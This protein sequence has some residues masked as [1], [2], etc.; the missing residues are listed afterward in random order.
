MWCRARL[1]YWP[2][3]PQQDY[4]AWRVIFNNLC[5]LCQHLW[6]DKQCHTYGQYYPQ[7]WYSYCHWPCWD[8]A[9]GK[10]LKSV[11]LDRN[12]ASS[13]AIKTGPPSTCLTKTV[14]Y[15]SSR[16]SY[17]PTTSKST[18]NNLSHTLTTWHNSD[19]YVEHGQDIVN[20]LLFT[21]DMSLRCSV[22]TGN[23]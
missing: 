11:I 8:M 20:S 16:I 17:H 1:F 2:V 3:P 4:V 10:K 5:N 23:F 15:N 18:H 14:H 12:V 13:N 7:V 9:L 22:L 21:C 19:N 6:L